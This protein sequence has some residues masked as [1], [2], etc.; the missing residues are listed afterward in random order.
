MWPVK[1]AH[2]ERFWHQNFQKTNLDPIGQFLY[3]LKSTFTDF[4]SQIMRT[5]MMIAQLQAAAAMCCNE[6]FLF[7]VALID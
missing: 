2:F 7:T 4:W 6:D 1:T 3:S 5:M